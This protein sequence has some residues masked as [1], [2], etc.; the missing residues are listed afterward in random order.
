LNT[1]KLSSGDT[2]KEEGVKLFMQH[3]Y[4]AANRAFQQA[5]DAY[6]AENNYMM[7]AEMKVNI[8]LVHR[9]LGES[10]QA[11]ELMT[12]ALRLFQ[13]KHDKLRTAQLLGNLGGVYLA[14]NDKER[15]ENSY[16][17]A[18]G[19]FKELGENDFRSD[20]LEALGRLQLTSGK[21]L[22]G[23]LNYQQALS[24]RKKLSFTQ[25]IIL[26][27]SNFISRMLGSKSA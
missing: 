19:I 4:E 6:E 8:G 9:S 27:L 22:E 21:Y 20:T 25:R 1:N 24:D 15:A 17:E 5:K 23:A 7:A 18:A 2:L 14:L 3:D 11:L 12:E 10:Q 26:M 16:R 13:E